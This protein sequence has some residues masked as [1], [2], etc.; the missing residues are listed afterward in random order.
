MLNWFA[1]KCPASDEDK[2]W[3]EDCWLWLIEEFSADAL[4]EV[5]VILPTDEFFPDRY[6]ANKDDLRALV[7]RVCDHMNVDFK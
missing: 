4:R 2:S 3:L 6:S 7:E 1:P 5:T